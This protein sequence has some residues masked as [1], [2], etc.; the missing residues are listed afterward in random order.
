MTA[1]LDSS[2]LFASA[3]PSD[4]GHG[5]AAALLRELVGD[6][7]VTSDHILVET[8]TLI[9]RWVGWRAARNWWLSIDESPV[10]V[11]CVSEVDLE[12]A[13]SIALAWDDQNFSLAD[14]S[15]FAVMERIGCRRVASFDS[16]FAIYRYGVGR[17]KAFD[18]LR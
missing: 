14:C 1:F 8:T 15:S 10:R 3:N 13:R 12:R 7:L 6:S 5:R 4:G 2:V 16:E 11:E 9:S 18:V 17:S